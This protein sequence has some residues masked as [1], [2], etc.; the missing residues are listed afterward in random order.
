MAKRNRHPSCE[1]CGGP[2]GHGRRAGEGVCQ[3][4]EHAGAEW[5]HRQLAR[6]WNVGLDQRQISE[7][8]GYAPG[9]INTLVTRLRRRGVRMVPHQ[10]AAR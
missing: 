10:A 5:G 1:V 8:L 3:G 6:L 2:L 9:S 4:C 7:Q